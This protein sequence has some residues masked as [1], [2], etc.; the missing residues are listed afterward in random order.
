[1][2]R[3]ANIQ[4]NSFGPGKDELVDIRGDPNGVI[5]G[6]DFFREFS[7]RVLKTEPFF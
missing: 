4:L 3:A 6:H 5:R 1:M 7:R 2:Y